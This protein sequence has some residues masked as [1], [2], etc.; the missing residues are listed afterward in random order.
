MDIPTGNLFQTIVDKINVFNPDI[1]YMGIGTALKWHPIDSI[2]E[3]NNQQYPPFLTNYSKKLIIL[4]DEHLEEPLYLESKMKLNLV[5]T[6]VSNVNIK[7]RVFNNTERNTIIFAI[8]TNFYFNMEEQTQIN[9]QFKY[10][11]VQI[12]SNLMENIIYYSLTNSKKFVVGDF[13]GRNIESFYV[14]LLNKYDE[15]TKKKVLNNIMF[16]VSQN[17]GGCY[18]EYDKSPILYDDSDNFIQVKYKS[19]IELRSISNYHYKININKRIGFVTYQ[20]SRMLRLL[21]NEIEGNGDFEG[22][23]KNSV[24]EVM[25]YISTIYNSVKIN[26]TSKENVQEAL[27][28]LLMDICTSLDVSMDI[29]VHLRENNYSQQKI[30]DTMNPLKYLIEN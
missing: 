8:N 25:N 28:Q 27:L 22:N 20:L 7:M 21:N 9:G 18:F 24:N 26:D 16:D 29:I 12:Q 17:D 5:E 13:S 15:N 3:N 19:L 23:F 11:L 2:N 10:N 4:I 6:I 14:Q 30:W 1:I